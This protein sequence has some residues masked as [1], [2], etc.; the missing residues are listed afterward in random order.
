LALTKQHKDEMLA[1]Y[2]DWLKRSQA[3]ILVEYTGARMKD[4]DAI[5]SKVRE[6]GGEFH[7]VKN[8]LVRRALKD[9]GMSMPEATLMKS[10]AMSFAFTDPAATAKALADATKGMSF[11]KVKAGF[12][13]GRLLDAT[14]VKALSELPPLPIMRAR[15]LGMLQAPAGQL[16]RTIV[17]PARSLAAV[18]RAYAETTQ[19]AS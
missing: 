7:V 13:A 11:V 19:V 9:Q 2:T 5:R 1:T 4:M 3:V 14:Q 12:M 17:E 16:V 18:F 8:T 15:L 6:S 10:S